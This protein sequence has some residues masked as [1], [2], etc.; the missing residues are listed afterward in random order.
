MENCEINYFTDLFMNRLHS[1]IWSNLEILEIGTE[2]NP[3][4][5]DT[6]CLL[7]E[8]SLKFKKLK[9]LR[10]IYDLE[11]DSNQSKANLQTI[12]NALLGYFG[13]LKQ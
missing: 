13:T 11:L 8:Y 6:L 5:N 3:V 9:I 12:L 1:N 2:V 7:S 4:P 10:L